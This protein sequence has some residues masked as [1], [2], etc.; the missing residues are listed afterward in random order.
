MTSMRIG[1]LAGRGIGIGEIASQMNCEV[2]TIRDALR[3]E[4]IEIPAN[5][6]PSIHVVVPIASFIHAID[7][8]GRSRRM[9][10]DEIG[11]EILR[12]ILSGGES[13]ICRVLDKAGVA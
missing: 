9:S 7:T 12:I 3:S 13:S 4:G 10:R 8:V 2:S 11:C 1:Y 6:G 5:H